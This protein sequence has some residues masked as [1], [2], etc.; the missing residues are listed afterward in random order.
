MVILLKNAGRRAAA[1]L[2]AAAVAV[3]MIGIGG[4]ANHSYASTKTNRMGFQTIGWTARTRTVAGKTFRFT[5]SAK[6]QVKVGKKYRTIQ[7]HSNGAATNGSVV[8]Y[9]TG[10]DDKYPYLMK[11]NLKTGK[12]SKVKLLSKK[13]F[14][15]GDNGFYYTFT[16]DAAFGNNLYLSKYD[17]FKNNGIYR[18]K[19]STKNL[20]RILKKG[21]VAGDGSSHTLI[22]TAG[23][24]YY[25]DIVLYKKTSGGLKKVKT[26]TKKGLRSIYSGGYFYYTSGDYLYRIKQNGQAKKRLAKIGFPLDFTETYVKYVGE[27]GNYKYYFKSGKRVKVKE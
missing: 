20:K 18:Y 7:S 26:L 19:L 22:S 21:D 15:Q 10:G 25:G 3:S 23:D 9:T 6:L 16:V 4:A 24:A 17:G 1:V 27:K 8:Y 5:T 13:K 14:W 2:L 12:R 11:Y